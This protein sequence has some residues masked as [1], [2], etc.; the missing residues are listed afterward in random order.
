[1]Y[2]PNC[3]SCRALS[4]EERISPGQVIYETKLWQVEHAYPTAVLGWLVI[5][6]KDHQEAVY[7]LRPDH[8]QELAEIQH[9]LSQAL[10]FQLHCTKIY[11][12]CFAEGEGFKHIHFHVTPKPDR[13]DSALVGPRIF[14]LMGPGKSYTPIPEE[15]VIELCSKL[16]DIVPFYK[17]P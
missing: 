17:F 15:Q 6:L 5:V 8:W 7:T 10:R 16:K 9:Q 1:M 3:K 11:I 13:L 14:G 12:S 2:N 4:G